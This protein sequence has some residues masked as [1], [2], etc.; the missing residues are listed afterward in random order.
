MQHIHTDHRII[1]NVSGR[2]YGDGR[3]LGRT[4]Y[5][6]YREIHLTVDLPETTAAALGPWQAVHLVVGVQEPE[7]ERPG[8]NTADGPWRGGGGGTKMVQRGTGTENTHHCMTTHTMDTGSV[9]HNVH[10]IC[11][12]THSGNVTVGN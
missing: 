9:V 4:R 11:T 7:T 12:S 6:L 5:M 8:Q 10:E 2:L 1:K 3:L